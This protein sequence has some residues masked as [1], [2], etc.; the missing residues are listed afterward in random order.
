MNS[1]PQSPNPTPVAAFVNSLMLGEPQVFRHVVLF[2]LS[3]AMDG[4]PPYLTLGEALGAGT[5][6]V[7]ETS[8]AGSVPELF[9]INRGEE[10]VLLVDG[11]ELLGAKQNRVLNT[12]ILLKPRSETVI[13]VSCTERGRWSYTQAASFQESEA[14][15]ETRIRSRKVG[16]VSASLLAE[17]GYASDQGEVWHGIGKLSAKAAVPSQTHAM[18]D[19]FKSREA[20]LG[21]A[22]DAFMLLPGQKGLLVVVNGRVGG[23]D[24]LSLERPFARLHRKLV[25]SYVLDALLDR[26]AKPAD[27]GKSR[28]VAQAFLR[29]AARCRGRSFPSA[30]VGEDARFQSPTVSGSALLEENRVVHTAFFRVEKSSSGESQSPRGRHWIIE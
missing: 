16:S 6:E 21:Q 13:P 7:T 18:H 30:G 4:V 29:R 28:R 22:L 5:V 23:F 3:T 10:R 20:E 11:E 2:P 17:C 19:V 27:P 1:T 24:A 9:V 12:S 25:K 15:L 26:D 14:M 8:Q